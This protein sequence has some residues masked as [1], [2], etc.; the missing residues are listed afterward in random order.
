[1][2]ALA[3][4]WRSLVRQPAR[5][6]LGI[7]GVA[8]VGALLFDM[9]LLSDGL[10]TSMRE[11][12][13]RT[14]FDIRVTATGDL[15]RGGR[16]IAN[17]SAVTA[18]FAE[19][20]EVERALAIRFADGVIVRPQAGAASEDDIN[21][22]RVG[23]EAV[24][25]LG[26]Q[27]W[28]VLQGRDATALNEVVINQALAVDLGVQVGERLPVRARCRS[29]SEILPPALLLVVGV[30]EFP[31][32][33]DQ[34][35]IGSTMATL[36][37][38]CGG[39]S[40]DE[41][42]AVLVRAAGDVDAAAAALLRVR[43]DVRPMTNEQ[44]VG[45]VRRTGFTYF[46]QI[47]AVLTTVTLG[48]ALL[49]ITVLLTVSVNQRLGEIAALRALGFSRARVVADV[50]CESMLIVGLGGALSLPLGVALANG[51]DRIL[52]DMPGIPSGMH[53]FVFEPRALAWHGGLLAVTAI[54]AALYPMRLVARLPIASTLRNEVVS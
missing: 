41:A 50:L 48:F 34:H 13:E 23:L 33:I 30:A 35:V 6:A 54:A 9:L 15:P 53:F 52:I 49:L 40:E 45:R 1:M 43:P 17:A 31:L 44:V 51:L 16:R 26:P 20:P 21:P 37:A 27:P 4:A 5:A 11:M 47:S 25:G 8:A 42:D 29:R 3:F 32:T 39:N 12:L 10:V 19:L 46:Q 7:L 28:T 22:N 18:A 24:G 36:D 2:K 38:A 14:G